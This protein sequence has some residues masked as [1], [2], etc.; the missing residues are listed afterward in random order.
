MQVSY[1]QPQ[2]PNSIAQSLSNDPISCPITELA[3]KC[4]LLI[5]EYQKQL[6]KN[7]E[8][9]ATIERYEK[10]KLLLTRSQFFETEMSKLELAIKVY[11]ETLKEIEQQSCKILAQIQH[12]SDES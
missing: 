2:I 10:E 11:T 12:A 9:K 7:Q 3:E 6:R 1:E 4:D 5:D 8:L